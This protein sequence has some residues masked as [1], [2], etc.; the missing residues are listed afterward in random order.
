MHESSLIGV[1]SC[2]KPINITF[3]GPPTKSHTSGMSLGPKEVVGKDD[4][5]HF[6]DSFPKQKIT[7][8]VEPQ[9]K[10]KPSG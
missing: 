7:V 5:M 2:T 6:Q 9:L 8:G 3:V 1:M 10:N 4:L